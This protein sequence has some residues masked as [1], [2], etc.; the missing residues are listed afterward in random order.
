MKVGSYKLVFVENA[1]SVKEVLV[2]K[3]ADY[4][5]RPPF[6]SSVMSTLG[7]KDIAAGDYGPAC[8]VSS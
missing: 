4:A 2:K 6:Y 8:E 5:G 7:G 1:D 3:S